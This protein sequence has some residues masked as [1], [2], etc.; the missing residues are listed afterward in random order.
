M[1]IGIIAPTK[2]LSKFCCLTEIQYCIPKLIVEDKKYRDFFTERESSGDLIILDLRSLG[3]KRKPESLEICR[4]ALELL[5]RPLVVL[6][7]YMYEVKRTLEVAE[8]YLGELRPS[9]VS[10]CIEGTDSKEAESCAKKL[11]ELGL[12][13]LSIPAHLYPFF[14]TFNSEGPRVYLDNYQKIEELA[15]IEG[16][17]VTSLPVRLG[18]DGRLL[19][20]HTPSPPSLTYSEDIAFPKIVEKNIKDAISYY[21]GDQE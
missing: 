8:V 1:E 17:L 6:P 4:K 21:E 20:D 2:L 16:T 13:T 15:G 19:S 3:W 14:K 12:R 18:L 5:D 7:S 11:K 9:I 10:G